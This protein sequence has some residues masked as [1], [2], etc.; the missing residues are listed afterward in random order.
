MSAIESCSNIIAYFITV[1]LAPCA[2]SEVHRTIE[3]EG[4]HDDI[5]F[6]QGG[7]KW[8]VKNPPVATLTALETMG[9][10]TTR[11]AIADYVQ[12]KKLLKKE[13]MSGKRLAGS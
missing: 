12:E 3:A 7:E 6:H 10:S 2:I 5:R 9:G 1:A 4:W 13:I 8:R 11:S